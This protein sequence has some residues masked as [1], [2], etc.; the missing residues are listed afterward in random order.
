AA[1]RGEQAPRGS[2]LRSAGHGRRCGRER[3]PRHRR[4]RWRRTP[5]TFQHLPPLWLLPR[6]ALGMILAKGR[7][8][9]E[10]MTTKDFPFVSPSHAPRSARPNRP[11]APEAPAAEQ[12]PPAA[13]HGGGAGYLSADVPA[14]RTPPG[15]ATGDPRAQRPAEPREP[16][17]RRAGVCRS[18][19]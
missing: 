11:R 17:L 8:T 2:V 14:A 10:T 12:S 9:D 1:W 15:S 19:A 4:T 7:E 3:W 13:Y 6:E 16:R 5:V 18:D